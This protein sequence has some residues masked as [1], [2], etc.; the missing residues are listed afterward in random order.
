MT[1]RLHTQVGIIGAGPAGLVAAAVLGKAGIDHLVL[2]HQ[3]REHIEQ[4]AR[5]GLL[6]HRTVEY[7]RALGLA[8]RLVAEGRRSGWSDFQV[9]GRRIRLDYAGLTGGYQHWVYPQQLLVRD[10]GAAL[11]AVGQAPLYSRTAREVT[12]LTGRRPVIVCDDVEIECDWVIGCDGFQGFTRGLLPT[13]AGF[14]QA[15][16][17]RYPYDTLTL[18]AEVDRPAEG[19]VYAVAEAGFAGMMPRT[20]EVSRFYL[21]CVN[22]EGPADWPAERIREQLCDRLADGGTEP[23]RIGAVSEVRTLLMRSHVS[24][25]LRHGRLLLAGD[26]AHLLTPF[27]GKGANLAIADAADLTH[28]LIRHYHDGDDRELDTYSERRLRDI[29]RVQEFSDQLLRLVLLP[30]EQTGPDARRFAL[31]LKLAAI[32]R[33]TQPGPHGAAFAHQYVGSGADTDTARIPAYGDRIDSPRAPAG[34]EGPAAQ[35]VHTHDQ[36]TD[37]DVH[38]AH[39]TG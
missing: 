6:E 16:A 31:R 28:A 17:L 1:L 5:A 26:S 35:H 15:A 22:G 2:E 18:L 8:D 21:Q 10:L 32:E 30:P 4:R 19:V 33:V 34:S 13:G 38:A 24:G 37:P 7:L 36:Q 14:P 25:S 3:S 11:A 39:T 23:P 9:L 29:W 20:P 27:G 12:G